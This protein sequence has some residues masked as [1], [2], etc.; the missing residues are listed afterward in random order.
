VYV[1]RAGEGRA[2]VI[3]R[4]RLDQA[5]CGSGASL[6]WHGSSLLYRSVDGTGVAEAAVLAPDGSPTRLT[7]LLRALPRLSPAAP[8]N[9]FW[10]T[11]FS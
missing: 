2:R 5:G 3:Y 9:V 7:P 10:A 1:L 4:H 11:E 6:D 8:G